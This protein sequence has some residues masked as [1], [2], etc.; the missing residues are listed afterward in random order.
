MAG[1]PYSWMAQWYDIVFEPLLTHAKRLGLQLYTPEPGELVLD[2]GC[3]TGAQLAL[4]LGLGC[5]LVGIDPAQAMVT[6]ARKRL[7]SAAQIHFGSASTIPYP[8]A[9]V[10]LLLF[11]MVLH[12]LSQDTRV[13]VMS[14]AK[15][16]LKDDGRIIVLD[17]HPEPLSV[18]RG[19]IGRPLIHVVEWMAG[20]DH[21]Q[22]Y[23]EFLAAGGVPAVAS[24][25]DVHVEVARIIKG[26]N[27]GLFLLRSHR[28]GAGAAGTTRG[29]MD[30]QCTV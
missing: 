13:A 17:Y 23:R 28:H 1:D 20:R 3:G 8:D 29:A 11:S 9:S 12:E 21:F 10:D 14:E 26:G 25:H 22:H 16:V 27:F 30:G 15:R 5:S 19:W 18:P 7:G 2:A 24:G 6:R 4:Y